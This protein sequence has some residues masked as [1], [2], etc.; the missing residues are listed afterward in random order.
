MILVL[1]ATIF[2]RYTQVLPSMA[3]GKTTVAP[4]AGATRDNNMAMGNPSNAT[5]DAKNKDNYL[6]VKPVYT[7]SYNNSKGIPNWVSWHL[8]TAWLGNTDRCNCF[9]ADES[10]PAAFLQV[11]GT[12]YVGSGFDRGHLC[13]SADRSA[14]QE[15]NAATFAMTNMA[16]QAP[17]LNEKTWEHFESYCRKLAAEGNE[18]YIIAGYYGSHGEGKKGYADTIAGG[19]IMVP[20]HFWKIAVVLPVGAD[21]VNRITKNTRVIAVY[22]PNTQSVD[23]YEWDHYRTT[24]DAIETATGYDFLSEVPVSIQ[25][26][27]EARKDTMPVN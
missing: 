10:L 22:M 14:T 11:R 16:P 21:D 7:L 24:V 19:K 20:S 5:A 27:I 9:A 3:K 25:K 12:N 13:P 2:F 26:V 6:L 17:V 4:V 15:D 1:V 18:L 23:Q 8:S